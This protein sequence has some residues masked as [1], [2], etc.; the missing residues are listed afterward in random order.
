M[1]FVEGESLRTRME[2]EGALP[3]GDAVRILREVVDALAAAR[4]A[5]LI[6]ARGPAGSRVLAVRAR[7]IRG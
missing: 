6:G 1:P 4:D 2:R 5:R 7:V 3:I